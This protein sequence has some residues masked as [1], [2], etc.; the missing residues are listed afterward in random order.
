MFSDYTDTDESDFECLR[1]EDEAREAA[2]RNQNKEV[3][4]FNEPSESHNWI[5]CK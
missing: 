3:S 4:D 2:K 5:E 1:S